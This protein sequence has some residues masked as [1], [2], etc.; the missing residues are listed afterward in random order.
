M[1]SLKLAPLYLRAEEKG[2]DSVQRHSSLSGYAS[3]IACRLAF[4]RGSDSPRAPR[5]LRMYVSSAPSS[6]RTSVTSMPPSVSVPVLSRQTVSTRASPSIAGSSCTRHCFRPRRMTP[7][8]KATEVSSTSPSGTIGTM[9]PTVRAIASLKPE[10]SVSSAS[11]LM[12]RPRAVGIIIHVTYLRIVEMPVRSSE[13]TSVKREASSASCAAYASRPTLVAVNAPPP[14]TTKLPD[15]TGSPGFLTT[16]SA[17]P[18]SSDSSISSPS[19]SATAPSTT[20]LSPGPISIRSPRTI[21]EVLISAD[22][23]SRRTVGLASPINARESSVF[24]ARS[25]WM[26]PMPVLARIT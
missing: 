25:S 23:P 12:I 3:M 21:S 6:A 1:P 24:L 7:I 26:M 20:I 11:W 13:W 10:S 4:G 22:T 14:A 9:P 19:A 5:T 2:S 15:I 8:A 18:V 16:G 17:S